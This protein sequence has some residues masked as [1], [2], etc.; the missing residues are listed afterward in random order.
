MKGEHMNFLKRNHV[1]ILGITFLVVIMLGTVACEGTVKKVARRMDE[2]A[3]TIAIMQNITIDAE[4]QGL[5]SKQTHNSILSATRRVSL[6]G[7]EIVK[8]LQEMN[9]KGIDKFNVDDVETVIK[10]LDAMSS[11]LDPNK[12]AEIAAIEDADTRIGIQTGFETA[13]SILASVNA[14]LQ[15]GKE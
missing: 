13:R 11:A 15:S 12:I 1:L 10:Y 8:I 7:L 14:M 9:A 5:I 2:V 3:S 6:A 4:A